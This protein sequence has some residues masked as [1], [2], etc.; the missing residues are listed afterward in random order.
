MN[1]PAASA[2]TQ[3]PGAAA[4]APLLEITGLSV[5]LE[6]K[7]AKRPVLRDVSLM[8]RRG[9]ALG[10]VGESG[11]GKTMTARAIGR[12]LPPGAEVHGSIRFGGTDIGRS[13]ARSCASTAA[14][15][16]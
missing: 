9:E 7:G 10:L 13:L 12:L 1:D 8:V 2:A 4:S 3:S 5:M 15:W 11:S 14:R 16:R 6:M